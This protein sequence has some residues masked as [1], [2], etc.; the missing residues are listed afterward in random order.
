MARTAGSPPKAPQ[1][2][3]GYTK[4]SQAEPDNGAED[5]IQHQLRQEKLAKPPS[6]VI[7]SRSSTLK[8]IAARQ[9]YETVAEVFALKEKE[10]KEDYNDRRRGKG[11]RERLQHRDQRFGG[12]GVRLMDFHGY[13]RFAGWS[14][15]ER[16]P[17]GGTILS[18]L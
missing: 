18:I 15:R 9:S 5:C 17:G 16:L 13:R 1:R 7:E 14:L 8:I 3:T 6:R 11:Y 12:T 2:C 10:D 4:D